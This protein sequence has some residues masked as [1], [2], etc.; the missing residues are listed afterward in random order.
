MH[1]RAQ[2][3]RSEMASIR[4]TFSQAHHD[5]SPFQNG[6]AAFNSTSS[7]LSVSSNTNKNSSSFSAAITTTS[8][9]SAYLGWL[10]ATAFPNKRKDFPFEIKLHHVNVRLD[11]IDNRS[12]MLDDD[13]P[14]K[15]INLGVNTQVSRENPSHFNLVSRKQL[16]VVTSTYNRA[17]QGYFLSSLG[18]VLQLLQ[19]PLQWIVVESDAASMDTTKI[20]RKTSFMYR[21]LVCTKNVK[22]VKDRAA[23]RNQS[24]W[25]LTCGNACAKQEQSN[26]RRLSAIRLLNKGFQETTFI[27]LSV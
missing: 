23:K 12:I 26:P 25:H 5:R 6:N 14:I 13:S 1:L 19:P 21:H 16:I 18:Q 10:L 15:T 4:C 8:S 22:D 11:E 27:E 2:P 20:L 24:I 3:D 17:S 7:S 9:Y